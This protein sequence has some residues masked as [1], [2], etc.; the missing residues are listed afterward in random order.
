VLGILGA[1]WWS[2]SQQAAPVATTGDA[3]DILSAAPNSIAVLRFADLSP[4]RDQAYFADGLAEEILH[5]LAQSPALRVTARTSSF[6][7][8]PGVEDISTI[9]Q[10]L[11]VDYVLEGSVRRDH[12]DLR[13][14]AQLIDSS[15]SYHVWSRT[16]DRKF[17]GILEL[18]REIAADVATA[19]KV[20]LAE[21][22]VAY[23]PDRAEAHEWFLLARHLYHRRGPGD[24]EAALDKYRRALEVDPR[25][26]RAWVGMAAVYNVISFEGWIDRDEGVVRQGEALENA[27]AIDPALVEAHGRIAHYLFVTGDRERALE[28]LRRAKELNPEEDIVLKIEANFAMFEGRVETSVA[29]M[30]RLVSRDPLSAIRRNSLASFLL[31]AGRAE[32]ALTQFR[33][34]SQLS[35]EQNY[36]WGIARALLIRGD[37]DGAR[38]EAALIENEP[39]RDQIEA[40]L[41]AEQGGAPAVTRLASDPDLVDKL[42]LAEV[43]AH[44]GDLDEAFEWISLASEAI[45][46]APRGG[47]ESRLRWQMV[48]SPFFRVLHHDPRWRTTM[49]LM[50]G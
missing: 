24:I 7:F 13:I 25:H 17:S 34:A 43:F 38:A 3:P 11:G 48:A 19:M 20:T 33:R 27:L 35:P 49:E 47:P 18:Q 31:A 4:G 50:R 26:A 6:A 12:D 39:W 41:D 5:L 28:S 32:E 36:H 44:R 40:L 23:S 9:A 22:D 29:I 37:Y 16:Y 21:T 14:T 42:L 30:E 2:W 8:D 45:I 15:N 46:R 10:Q 1:G